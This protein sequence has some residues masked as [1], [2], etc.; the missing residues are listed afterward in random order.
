MSKHQARVKLGLRALMFG[1]FSLVAAACTGGESAAP[2]ETTSTTSPEAIAEV[3]VEEEPEETPEIPEEPSAP[4][5][6]VV[7]AN[8]EGSVTLEWDES[9]DETVTGYVVSRV[10]SI[11]GTEV[12]ETAEPTVTDTGLDDG[13][14]FTYTVAAIN[15]AGESERSEPISVQVGVDTNP[16]SRPGTPRTVESAEGVQIDWR[17][18]TDF[19][20][21][22]GYIVTRLLDGETTEI[23][24]T[25][26][27]LFDDV[28]PG[29]V[30]TYRV[31][32][33][34]GAGNESDDSRNVTIL[35]GTAAEDVIV[36]VS[37]HADPAA[38]ANAARLQQALLDEGFVVTWFED[39]VFD[40]NVTTADDVVLLLGDVEGQGF[41][42]NLF[43]TDANTI[44]LKSIFFVPSGFVDSAP[45]TGRLTDIGYS[46]PGEDARFLPFSNLAEPRPSPFIPMLQWLPDFEVWATPSSTAEEAVA[47]LIRPGGE[48]A[49]EREAPACRA[50]F[51]GNVDSLGEQ[52]E[53]AWDLLIEFVGSVS[54]T[55]R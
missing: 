6:L 38:D 27:T 9:R 39:N 52:S 3:E 53:Q 54:E 11:G 16:P 19:S 5:G 44:T 18:S 31:R 37:T 4:V 15:A 32:S 23:E 48:L 25:E 1:A 26:P 24:T 36:V 33:V 47:G 34:D 43:G 40:S 50:F 49:N 7:T 55:C 14:V 42:W 35:S 2:A 12:F 29:Q 10:A 30:V 45:R 41:D 51:P 20:G 22:D 46:P 21:I 17:A 8:E 13:D 28:A